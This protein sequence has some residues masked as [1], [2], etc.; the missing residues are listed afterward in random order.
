M[1]RHGLH[2]LDDLDTTEAKE[3]EREGAQDREALAL[4]S[5]ILDLFGVLGLDD[6]D[7]D[8]AF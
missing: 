1:A 7:L 3:V 8:P 5:N 6:F 2:F 4:V